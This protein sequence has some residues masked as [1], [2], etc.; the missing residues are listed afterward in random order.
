MKV[1]VIT[2]S[3]LFRREVEADSGERVLSCIQC[4]KCS[5]SCPAFSAMDL[6]PRR[7]MR[8]VQLGLR[9]DALGSNTIWLCLFCM[10]CSSRCP[11][12]IDVARVIET[13]RHQA[14]KEGVR[15]A[16]KDI[17][18]FHRIFLAQVQALGKNYELGLAGAY[19]ILSLRPWVNLKQLPASL[20]RGKLPFI[21]ERAAG[22]GPLFEKARKAGG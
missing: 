18:L 20:R 8:A 1:S 4:G 15:P 13:L 9:E 14:I 6:G 11:M 22:T 16:E 7:L 3:P 2:P 12:K 19:S 5:G 10:T 17:A 21:P